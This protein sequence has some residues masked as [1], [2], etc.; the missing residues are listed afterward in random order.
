M[1]VGKAWVGVR[2]GMS[3]LLHELST[4][5]AVIDAEKAALMAEM[6]ALQPEPPP[7]KR[8]LP[9]NHGKSWT[10]EEKQEIAALF[11][12]GVSIQEIA[13]ARQR[14]RGSIRAELIRQGL[15]EA[16]PSDVPPTPAP[17][18]KPKRMSAAIPASKT[19]PTITPEFQQAFD[20]LEN[21]RQNVF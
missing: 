15:I 16:E 8:D 7:S 10:P 6:E 21:M 20:L 3:G 5:L 13:D 14:T 11:A 1:D 12:R 2:G 17:I 4:R 9:A 19:L 18:E